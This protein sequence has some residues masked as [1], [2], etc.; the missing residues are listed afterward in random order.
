MSYNE[1]THP[2]PQYSPYVR[3][4]QNILFPASSVEGPISHLRRIDSRVR[5][6]VPLGESGNSMV[7][8]IKRKGGPHGETG[9]GKDGGD[10]TDFSVA[11]VKE[12]VLDFRAWL[13]FAF[14]ILVTMQ[15]PVLT[16]STCFS[17]F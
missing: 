5:D 15:S 4:R 8:D 13:V 16:V 7:L 3:H 11:Q 2:G 1:W 17:P 14:G 6:S 12:S 10:Q 9:L